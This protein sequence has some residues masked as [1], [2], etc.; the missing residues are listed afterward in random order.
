MLIY[1]PQGMATCVA[2]RFVKIE[3]IVCGN[4]EHEDLFFFVRTHKS[5][6]Y[7]FSEYPNLLGYG[8]SVQ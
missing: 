1:E 2:G 4:A 6:E 8:D 5:F 7:L 3:I